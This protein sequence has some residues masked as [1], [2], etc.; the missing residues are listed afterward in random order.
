M[1][2]KKFKKKKYSFFLNFLNS[3]S[4]FLVYR[5]T[6]RDSPERGIISIKSFRHA[7]VQIVHKGP[8]Y[9]YI[10]I[11][12]RYLQFRLLKWPLIFPCMSMLIW[13]LVFSLHVL[14]TRFAFCAFYS[15]KRYCTC[16]IMY[17]CMR[18]YCFWHRYT[19]FVTQTRTHTRMY[20]YINTNAHTHTISLPRTCM[21]VCMH[22]CNV[23]YC[24]VA[25]SKV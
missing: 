5:L 25:Q 14:C 7:N 1:E 6:S 16:L 23:L 8:S 24:N 20:I 17:H 21:Y 12:G 3:I 9:I 11:Y 4:F 22:A 19:Q 18:I 2:F 13:S 10:Y 15:A